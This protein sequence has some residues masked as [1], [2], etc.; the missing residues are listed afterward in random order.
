MSEPMLTSWAIQPIPTPTA[1]GLLLRT[2]R[3][4]GAFP[5]SWVPAYHSKIWCKQL[6]VDYYVYTL[7]RVIRSIHIAITVMDNILCC[8]TLTSMRYCFLL[9]PRW[10]K[11]RPEAAE[12]TQGGCASGRRVM[13]SGWLKVMCE[14]ESRKLTPWVDS[15]AWRWW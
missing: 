10:S 6:H 15:G 4:S 14:N 3:S 5:E 7:C 8:V 12:M 13:F 11:D 9:S 2:T 1:R